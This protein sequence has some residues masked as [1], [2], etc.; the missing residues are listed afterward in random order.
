MRGPAI[1]GQAA[2]SKPKGDRAGKASP[3]KTQAKSTSRPARSH[4]TGP[5]EQKSSRKG[6]K[7]ELGQP[8]CPFPVPNHPLARDHRGQ[9]HAR[10]SQRLPVQAPPHPKSHQLRAGS[11]H[12]RGESPRSAPRAAMSVGEPLRREPAKPRILHPSSNRACRIRQHS[13]SPPRHAR[14]R[15][16]KSPSASR[17]C[18]ERQE[19]GCLL[20]HPLPAR[21]RPGSP[22]PR[23]Q[24]G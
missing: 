21:S 1:T 23:R 13:R 7:R 24:R 5:E 16:R 19:A 22:P 9:S 18:R 20:R 4:R 15:G 6:W 14:G 11:L 8:P 17:R 2:S 12:R 10:Q 3:Q